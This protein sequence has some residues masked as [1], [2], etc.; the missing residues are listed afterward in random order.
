M[1]TI[2]ANPSDLHEHDSA[3]AFFFLQALSICPLILQ[4]LQ[5]LSL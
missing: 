1:T 3:F 5:I 2:A 4:K